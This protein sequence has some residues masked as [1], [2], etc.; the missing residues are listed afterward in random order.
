[1]IATFLTGGILLI[2]IKT[3]WRDMMRHTALES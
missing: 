3:I 1:M 2:V